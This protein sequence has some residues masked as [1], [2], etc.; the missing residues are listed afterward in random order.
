MKTK[1]SY[2]DQYKDRHGKTRTYYRRN[3]Q[4]QVI[5]GEFG[6]PEWLARYTEIHK[7]FEAPLSPMPEH[8]TLRF[9]IQQYL[10]SRRF[11]T[12]AD[13]T[14]RAYLTALDPLVEKL[15]GQKLSDFTRGTV[16]K[17]RDTIANRSPSMAVLSV[18]VLKNVFQHACD[19]DMIDRNPAKGVEGPEAHKKEPYRRWT[20]EELRHVVENG[21]P[22]VR[23]AMMVLMYTGL[24]CSDAVTLQRSSI[25]NGLISLRTKKTGSE[26]IIPIH[27]L[28]QQELNKQ[29]PVGSL[30]LLP[31]EHGR[32][33]RVN[34]VW[35]YFRQHFLAHGFEE[36]P[37]THGL[38]KNAVTALVESGCS[39]RE[40]QA[41][42]G[43]SLKIIEHY[44]REYDR[45]NL[46]H[47]A[48][49]KWEGY[50]KNR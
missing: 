4:R 2:I 7:S 38:R 43:Q 37:T 36:F 26:V 12:K 20:E 25:R 32:Q 50:T 28:L 24:R 11:R 13:S 31:N 47:G 18:A 16:I 39:P 44:A 17:I 15:G 10:E 41:I 1:L 30:F 45:R 19:T 49:L 21:S 5:E 42:T 29:L 27:S 34:S 6:S 23:R 22:F 33:A 8:D 9:A 3:G 14:K 48:V 40:I 46:A 35:K